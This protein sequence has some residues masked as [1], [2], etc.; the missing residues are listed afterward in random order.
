MRGQER[1]DLEG[2]EA[3]GIVETLE[4][5]RHVV[6]RQGD[7]ALDSRGGRV[8]AASKELELRSTLWIVN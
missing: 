1:D 7:E 6:G 8:L 2:R 4:N 5:S 3:T